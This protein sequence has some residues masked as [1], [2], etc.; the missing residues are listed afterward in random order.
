MSGSKYVDTNAIIQIIGDILVQ[1]SL[2]NDEGKYFFSE[3]DFPNDFHKTVFGAAYNLHA[4][5]ATSLT[6]SAI[7]DYLSS[8]PKREALYTTNHGREWIEKTKDN[9]DLTNFDY[10]YSR[11]KKMTLLRGYDKFGMNLSWLY[12]PDNILDIK[13]KQAQEDYLDSL[14]L[15]EIAQTIDDKIL[16]IKSK[17]IDNAS[18]DSFQLGSGIYDL[19]ESLKETPEI[20][21]PMYG[22]FVNTI[23]RGARLK[24]FYLRSAATGK[25]KTRTM[26]AD[27]CFISCDEIFE[28]GEWKKNGIPQPTLLISTELELSEIQTL[29]LAFIADVPEDKI[30]ESKLDFDENAR[31]SKAAEVISRSPIYLEELPDFSLRDIENTIKRNIRQHGCQYIV[32]DYIHTSMKILE[33]ISRRSGGVKLRED[34]ILFLLSVK[35]KDICNEFGV[36]VLSGTQLNADYTDSKH[37]DQNLLRGAKAIADKT[38]LGEILLEPTE[39]DKAAIAG[40]IEKGGFP[41]PNIKMS[42]YKN[43][44]GRYNN[45]YCWMKADYATCRFKTLF[46]TTFDYDLLHIPDTQVIVKDGD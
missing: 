34:N 41:V 12:D 35:L 9:A 17:Y 26:V 31:V 36:F 7:E 22:P 32:L 46:I 44:R 42:I 13:K 2:L 24:K 20:G 15:E 25:G 1:P 3:D 33:E 18:D 28:D 11:L 39:E 5:G 29:A 23:T 43:R 37:P 10:Y 16:A 40:I 19:I 27:A 4:M 8:R 38:D 21:T 6:S 30:L 14:T 45:I